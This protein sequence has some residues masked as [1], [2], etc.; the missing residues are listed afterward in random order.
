ME[1]RKCG[2]NVLPTVGMKFSKPEITRSL[3]G[4]EPMVFLDAAA[5]TAR[6]GRIS[7][8]EKP[9][10]VPMYHSMSVRQQPYE[11]KWRRALRRAS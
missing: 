11:A 10:Q 8:A 2:D 9:V 4:E 6:I 3:V 1:T 5:L 7:P